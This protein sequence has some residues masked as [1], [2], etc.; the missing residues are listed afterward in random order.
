[1]PIR[2]LPD[3]ELIVTTFL[4]AHADLPGGVSTELPK[5]PTWPWLTVARV[6]GVPSIANYLDVARLEIS[7]WAAT[8]AAALALARGA[9][10]AVLSL[11]GPQVGAVVTGVTQVGEGLQWN[12]DQETDVPRYQFVIELYLYPA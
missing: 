9:E 6:G 2:V 3:A 8:K 10:A 4:R 7:S 1:M 11:P 12:P 5:E